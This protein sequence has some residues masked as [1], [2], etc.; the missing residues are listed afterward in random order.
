MEAA[1]GTAY[2]ARPPRSHTA[3]DAVARVDDSPPLDVDV[4]GRLLG[5]RRMGRTTFAH[6]RDGSGEIQL[7]LNHQALGGD[8]YRTALETLDVGDFVSAGGPL[9]RTRTTEPSV[10]VERLQVAAKALRPLPAKWHGL[11]DAETRFRQRYL[12]ILANDDVRRR[13]EAR[14]SIVSALRRV[15]D[16]QG[17]LEVETP[18]L[19]PVYGGGAAEP[20]VTSY[21]AL[22]R[23]YFLRI[24]DELYLK[25][26]L[27][28]GYERVYEICKNFR[29]EGIDSSHCP[30]FTMLECYQAFADLGDMR[31]LAQQLVAAAAEA[32]CGT[33]RVQVDDHVLDFTPPW[34]RLSYRDALL[35]GAGVDLEGDS[36]RSALNDAAKANKVPVDPSWPRPK[37]LDELMKTLVEP[38]LVQTTFLERYPTETAP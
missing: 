15:L 6:L 29:N 35:A 12:D 17:F 14:T 22:D 28:A 11:H 20:F 26:L 4:A 19:Q 36:S 3:A 9:F 38:T 24:A 7:Y 30:E 37:L 31:D 21:A 13:F 5:L 25:R 8:A 32:A 27:V 23:D 10:R 1:Q 33:T 18:T 2:P 16:D 34:R